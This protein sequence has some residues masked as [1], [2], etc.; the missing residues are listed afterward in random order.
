[1]A[2]P[3]TPRFSGP[4]PCGTTP[5][6]APRLR[7]RAP[8]ERQATG[9]AGEGGLNRHPPFS[10]LRRGPDLPFLVRDSS[11]SE[12]H[13][14]GPAPP[15]VAVRSSAA[16]PLRPPCSPR[17]GTGRLAGRGMGCGREGMTW[18]GADSHQGD[19]LSP[20]RSG[21]R[22]FGGIGTQR[23]PVRTLSLE[24]NKNKTWPRGGRASSSRRS[25]ARC[26]SSNCSRPSLAPSFLPGCCFNPAATPPPVRRAESVSIKAYL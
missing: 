25:P 2:R 16:E 6:A 8:E 23:G 4:A 12:D 26:S 14:E 19:R 18:G 13:A 21:P 15:Q 20:G 22:S 10:G 17:A 5:G 9:L 7:R 3:R 11:G 1:M 24:N